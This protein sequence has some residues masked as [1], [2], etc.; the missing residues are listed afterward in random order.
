MRFCWESDED[1][2][3]MLLYCSINQCYQWG[4]K[5][6]TTRTDREEEEEEEERKKEKE[7]LLLSPL[8][9]FLL[10]PLF[11]FFFFFFFFSCWM[12]LFILRSFILIN[13]LEVVLLL[14]CIS[15]RTT[16]W[17]CF[18]GLT[19]INMCLCFA[20]EV[21]S[22][23]HF[24]SHDSCCVSRPRSPRIQ[25]HVRHPSSSSLFHPRFLC[26]LSSSSILSPFISSLSSLC[27]ISLLSHSPSPPL[28]S[29]SSSRLVFVVLSLRPSHPSL[30]LSQVSD[31]RQNRAGG[32]LQRHLSSG[33][34][35]L[36]RGLPDLLSARLQHLLQLRPRGLQTDSTGNHHADPGHGHG[37]PRRDPRLLQT[38]SGQLRLHGRGTRHLCEETVRL[39]LMNRKLTER[40]R[41]SSDPRLFMIW[42][43]FKLCNNHFMFPLCS[44]AKWHLIG[45]EWR[46]APSLT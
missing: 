7:F 2:N 25:Q 23:R 17:W 6:H 39:S 34:P 8:Y 46:T 13:K 38:E 9:V 41:K 33:E 40:R 19:D 21:H 16:D 45:F 18:D 11:V 1:N 37:S 22:G 26:L 31:Q 24:D 28:S 15:H 12:Y 30:S 27:S 3:I 32:S 10:L 44:E 42:C 14:W 29:S 35:S 20:G 36:C 43:S 5:R 4:M